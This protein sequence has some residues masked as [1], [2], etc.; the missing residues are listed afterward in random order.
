MDKVLGKDSYD[1]IDLPSATKIS[2]ET[3]SEFK[4]AFECY[5]KRNNLKKSFRVLYQL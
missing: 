5:E 4:A 2:T 1:L 3:Y